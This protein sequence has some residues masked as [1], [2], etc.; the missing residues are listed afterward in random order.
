MGKRLGK[1]IDVGTQSVLFPELR[2]IWDGYFWLSRRRPSGMG[3]GR[4]PTTEMLAWC[5]LVGIIDRELRV[6]FCEMIDV[7]DSVWFQ[8]YNEQ[9]S[10]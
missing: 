6:E 5:D 1:E 3:P 8:W 9:H 7:L 4:I 10:K 2:W